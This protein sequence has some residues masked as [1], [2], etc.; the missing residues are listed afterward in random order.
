MK[1]AYFV[2][3]TDTDAG[4][5]LVTTALLYLAAQQSLQTLA[6]KP[7][8]A[9]CESTPDGLRN[10]DA[11]KLQ[12]QATVAL[13]YDQVNPVALA[14][15]IAPHLAA[16]MR[17]LSADRLAAYCRG[18]MLQ[19][20]DLVFIEGAGG[21]RVP[22]NPRETLSHLVQMLQVPVILVVG[23]KLGCLNH[24]L[25]TAEAIARDG[26]RLAGWVACQTDPD[27]SRFDDNVSS[28]RQRLRAPLLGVIPWLE[29]PQ[30]AQA[31]QYLDL[32]VL[33]ETENPHAIN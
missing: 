8:A 20:A 21:W 10:A 11:L 16:G 13:S 6:L 14:D 29:D 27:M 24:A 31:A 32:S 17:Q 33:L 28:L 25:L 12:Q 2:T 15:P 18:V 23:M 7:L 9:G 30:P 26:V 22:L 3:A 5:T 19:K 1:Q 4:K